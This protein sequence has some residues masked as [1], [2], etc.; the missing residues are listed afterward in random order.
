MTTEPTSRDPAVTPV[1]LYDGACGFC[2]RSVA[3]LLRHE[4]APGA[5]RFAPLDG[6]FGAEVRARHP[7]LAGVD[8]VIWLEPAARDRAERLLVRSEAAL[9][10]SAYLRAPWPLLGRVARLVPRALR[11][12]AYALVARHRRRLGGAACL[13]PTPEERTRFL[14]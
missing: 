13:V 14:T 12:R 9:A 4:R 5:L 7:G 1:L 6:R 3:F 2:A 8:S 10:A 11:D